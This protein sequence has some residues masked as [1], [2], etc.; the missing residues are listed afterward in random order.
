MPQPSPFKMFKEILNPPP[1]V[2]VDL[3]GK[4]VVLVGA[5]SGI[6]FEAAK[7]FARMGPQRLILGFRSAERGEEAVASISKDTGYTTIESWTIDLASFAS[8]NAFAERF[9]K[10][11]GRLD[12]FVPN[13]A[14]LSVSL[15]FIDDGWET[16]YA[17][18]HISNTL[19]V[20]L[21]LPA[22]LE[23]ARVHNTTPRVVLVTS[24]YH[25]GAKLDSKLI[26]APNALRTYGHRDHFTQRIPKKSF[27]GS[28]VYAETKLLVIFFTRALNDRLRHKPIIVN[29]VDP[30]FV[31]SGLRRNL[32]GILGFVIRM[33][34]KLMVRTAEEGSRPM[35]W[36]A[37]GAEE[38]KDELRGAFISSVSQ[39]EETS[40]YSNSRE[41]FIAQNKLWV[42]LNA[43]ILTSINSA[44]LKENL[45]EELMQI[46]P[47]IQQTS[48]E[49]LTPY[50]NP[51]D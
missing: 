30:G 39:V 20:L 10:E 45:V 9:K 26:D 35:I 2:S 44:S 17:V 32:G 7:H 29:T 4:T 33:M 28:Q 22:M 34:E 31:K 16:M 19:L 6:G 41:G 15:D 14:V 11:G 40:D 5:N 48:Q 46:N 38:K 21:L 47:G 25:Y 3:S 12:I 8:V 1:L 37:V 24:G 42:N 36:A 51:T 13:A 50:N 23:T 18:N 43:H 27:D 49:C